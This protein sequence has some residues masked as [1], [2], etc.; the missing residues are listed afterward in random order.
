MDTEEESDGDFVR[1]MKKKWILTYDEW[2]RYADIAYPPEE[3]LNFFQIL[4]RRFFDKVFYDK[5]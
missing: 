3:N 1:R 2:L 5:L 4:K